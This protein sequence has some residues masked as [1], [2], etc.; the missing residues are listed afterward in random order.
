MYRLPIVIQI[1]AFAFCC[2]CPCLVNAQSITKASVSP[3][4]LPAAGGR[5]DVSAHVFGL[6]LSVYA[7]FYLSDN[8]IPVGGDYDL[9][10]NGSNFGSDYTGNLDAIPANYYSTSKIVYKVIVTAENNEG[11]RATYPA[12]FVS[13]DPLPPP[14][15]TGYSLSASLSP[16]SFNA[17]GGN[18]TIKAD[19]T[20]R[21]E[22][23]A[24]PP[25]RDVTIVADAISAG[26]NF[27][28]IVGGLPGFVWVCV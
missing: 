25:A 13:V 24:F 19:V 21:D 6:H 18:F 23:R 12:G 28:L 16:S 17:A 8:P 2:F 27:P 22:G 7:N 11:N 1:V 14:G 5:V 20:S 10:G 9:Q 26:D 3:S 4:K 15:K